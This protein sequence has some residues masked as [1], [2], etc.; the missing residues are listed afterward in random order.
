MPGKYT[1]TTNF[2]MKFANYNEQVCSGSVH[3]FRK[4]PNQD[5]MIS[6]QYP[7]IVGK[8][9]GRY[10]PYTFFHNSISGDGDGLQPRGSVGYATGA[11]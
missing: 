4:I 11:D 7:L 10:P 9:I 1:V 3:S 5:N 6:T 2:V 8:H